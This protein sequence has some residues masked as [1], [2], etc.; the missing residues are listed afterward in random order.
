MKHETSIQDAARVQDWENRQVK[1]AAMACKK[2]YEDEQEKINEL[3][4][5]QEAYEK[6]LP[7]DPVE[8]LELI[9]RTL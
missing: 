2:V 9:S 3:R 7:T 5:R 6:S 4:A 1:G 8:G